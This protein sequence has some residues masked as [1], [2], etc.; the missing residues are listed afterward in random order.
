MI[1][2]VER[3]S[4]AYYV[5]PGA[6]E[7]ALR[8]YQAFLG[9]PGRRPLYPQDTECSC[10]DCS[11]DDVRPARDVLELMR[12]EIAT[13]RDPNPPVFLRARR[14]AAAPARPDPLQRSSRL[15]NS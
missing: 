3:L 7:R 2:R 4:V 5:H 14:V 1:H 9:P 15:R 8:R 6:T 13:L 12:P 11:L 10:R